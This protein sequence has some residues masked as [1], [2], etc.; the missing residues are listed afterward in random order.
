[1]PG[2]ATSPATAAG[3]SAIAPSSGPPRRAAGCASLRGLLLR[4]GAR[5]AH[6]P[7]HL[8]EFRRLEVRVDLADALDERRMGREGAADALGEQEVRDFLRVGVH[9][10][11]AGAERPDLHQ[12]VPQALRVARELHGGGVR[13]RLAVARHRG[14][15]Q[16]PEEQ[17]DPTEREH[18]ECRNEDD[19]DAAPALLPA[20]AAARRK[21][22]DGARDHRD[23]R[24]SEQQP[25]QA[26]A[27]AHVAVQHVAE[28]VR[29]HALQLVAVEVDQRA[30]R[31]G[32]RG[33]RRAVAR[34]EG[35]DPRLALEHVHLGHRHAGGDR[36]LLDDVAQPP[37]ER[38]GRV[39]ADARAAELL[40]HLAAAGRERDG[41][42]E[43]RD[44]DRPQHH[45]GREEHH[46]RVTRQRHVRACEQPAV[47]L[48]GEDRDRRDHDEVD[49]DHDRDHRDDE[50]EHHPARLPPGG[51][52]PREEI[53]QEPLIRS[54]MERVTR[55][56]WR[57]KAR[58]EAR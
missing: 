6:A 40:R 12:R 48:H 17:P 34:R 44:A 36:D 55:A 3:A 10:A 20:A 4:H 46:H 1:M 18:D 8:V 29:D 47:V 7:A 26:R 38:V 11:R 54:R 57:D 16:P 42:R 43:A 30:A 37:L 58:A 50:Q 51:G 52:L 14:L 33:V 5:L 9:E 2:F 39:G 32:D 28:L 35:V 41:A 21:A 49:R 22:Q 56:P 13:Q 15:D 23:H 24:E 25:D 19:C 45:H 27:E 31:D 53:H